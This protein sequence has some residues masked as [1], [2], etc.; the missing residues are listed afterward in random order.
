MCGRYASSRQ[1]EDLVEEFEIDKVEVTEPLAARL[2]RRAH[3][4]G[5]R[6]RRAAAA[7]T[8]ED[9]PRPS[10]SCAC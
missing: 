7:R 6:R 2:Q 5:L 1:P 4:G 3:Q 9:R 8:D 10:A